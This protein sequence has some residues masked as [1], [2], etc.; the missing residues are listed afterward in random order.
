MRDDIWNQEQQQALNK[1]K[2]QRQQDS[3]L[4]KQQEIDY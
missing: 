1:A 2:N 3:V 4:L